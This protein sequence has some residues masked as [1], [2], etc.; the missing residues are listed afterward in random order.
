MNSPVVGIDIGEE[1]STV[2]YL[3]PE[4]DVRDNFEFDMNTDCIHYAHQGEEG[5]EVSGYFADGK[6]TLEA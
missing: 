4:G 2:T 6:Q 5:V 3:S 1:K